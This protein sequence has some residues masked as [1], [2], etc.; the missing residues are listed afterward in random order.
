MR[1]PV[2]IFS[3]GLMVALCGQLSPVATAAPTNFTGLKPAT[4]EQLRG[5]PLA[6]TP[7]S[8][9]DLPAKVDLS[10][11]M[12]PPGNQGNQNSCVGWATAYALKSYQEKIEERRSL[13]SQNRVNPQM[14]FSP[15]FVYNQINNGRDGGASFIDALNLLSSQ[16]AVSLADMPYRENDFAHRPAAALHQ[17]AKRYRIDYWRQVN[18]S[19]IKEVKAQLSAGYPVL[20][21]AMVDEGF[22][23]HKNGH[24]WKKK[25][26]KTLGGHAMVLVGY[27]NARQA[28]KLI[29]SW[30]TAWGDQGFG[31]IDYKL[32]PQVVREG[33]VAKDA[34]NGPAPQP[35]TAPSTEPDPE[36]EQEP[37]HEPDI[38]ATP[39]P[40]QPVA[41]QAQF[42][43]SDVEYNIDA[44]TPEYKSYGPFMK[45]KG[46]IRIPAGAGQHMQVVV[47]FYFDNGS[48]AKGKPVRTQLHELFSIPGEDIAA[49]ATARME[50]PEEGVDDQWFAYIPYS[51][52]KLPP[53]KVNLIGEPMLYVDNFGIRTGSLLRFWVDSGRS[54]SPS[55]LQTETGSPAQAARDF[56]RAMQA[57]D[58]L[59]AWELLTE[60]S[61]QQLCQLLTEE[62]DLTLAEVRQMF[63]D[64]DDILMQE[65]WPTLRDNLHIEQWVAQT[66]TLQRRQGTQAW[67]AAQ[68]SGA[69][70]TLKLEQGHWK[71]GYIESFKD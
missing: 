47:R 70:L 32:L 36:P 44:P 35:T 29:N 15:A 31:Y 62:T 45:L 4:P 46:P 71:L 57:E 64:G 2:A 7:F 69:S 65:F 52:F 23:K 61:Q 58:Y 33:Y 63:A 34:I 21:G 48:G 17:K 24:F 3:A 11:H 27:D 42:Q 8:G 30:G 19:D 38:E 51:A 60:T 66:Y 18:V 14:V 20:I 5:I 41:D 13:A 43:L 25:Q 59:A 39:A 49:T 6:A 40:E 53:G 1:H 16:G 50:I 26:G 22:L 28:F 68:P 37:G 12:P 10:P 54:E 9:T 67:V 56:F 55:E